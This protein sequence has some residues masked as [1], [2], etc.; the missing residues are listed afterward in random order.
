MIEHPLHKE[1]GH[2]LYVTFGKNVLRDPACGGSHKLPLFYDEPKSRETQLC[3]AD[4]IIISRNQESKVK[5]IMEIEETNLKPTQIFGKFLT[6]VF[7]KIL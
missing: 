5:V 6:S 2:R 4:I 7:V 1:I 3:N